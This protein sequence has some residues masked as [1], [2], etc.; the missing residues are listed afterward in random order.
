MSINIL[1][2]AKT[3]KGAGAT[4]Y[5]IL[6][7]LLG[8][9]A[10]GTVLT[11]GRQTGDTF[12]TADNTLRSSIASSQ[13]NNSNGVGN[14]NGNGNGQQANCFI[15]N[16]GDSTNNFSSSDPYDCFEIEQGN[17][18]LVVEKDGALSVVAQNGEKTIVLNG[19]GPHT[20]DMTDVNGGDLVLNTGEVTAI[21]SA[22]S[23]TALDDTTLTS[24]GPNSEG[25][26]FNLGAGDDTINMSNARIDEA[27]FGN[28]NN[29]LTHVSAT[30]NTL[31]SNMYFGT[32]TNTLNLGCQVAPVDWTNNLPF[33]IENVGGLTANIS[34]CPLY[35][36]GLPTSSQ[37]GD[38]SSEGPVSITMGQ[39]SDTVFISQSAGYS[40]FSL[41]GNVSG[42]TTVRVDTLSGRQTG[43]A[44]I[45][46]NLTADHL[47]NGPQGP[48]VLV[49][50][51][52]E[53]DLSKSFGG[54]DTPSAQPL[55][56]SFD[57]SDVTA[58]GNQHYISTAITY[59]TSQHSIDLTGGGNG[60]RFVQLEFANPATH[61]NI[62]VPSISSD[63][64][65]D[66]IIT[67]Q[68]CWAV[69]VHAKAGSGFSDVTHPAGDCVYS[70]TVN[71]PI[72]S[73]NM[74][75]YDGATLFAPNGDTLQ[76]GFNGGS[77]ANGSTLN[78]NSIVFGHGQKDDTETPGG[79]A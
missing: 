21:N 48:R 4:E 30:P 58:S 6:L 22:I 47:V 24:I 72:V 3:N 56:I 66:L 63:S 15:E 7:S 14:G 68:G 28:G 62:G 23:V 37:T 5:A 36:Y 75:S 44:V 1:G 31:F 35:Y 55:S 49:G 33:S 43:P 20:V 54:P 61:A 2:K 32:G 17:D 8:A 10:I 46:L 11:L 42:N 71:T 65:V 45:D 39:P 13:A 19:T 38:A 25:W 64:P 9:V 27:N 51:A 67:T 29:S 60:T 59:P 57:V 16:G 73:S 70:S 53:P 52:F 12:T 79:G 34:G 26:T 18:T 41:T 76:L 78:L 40:N 50:A 69:T 77:F 74:S